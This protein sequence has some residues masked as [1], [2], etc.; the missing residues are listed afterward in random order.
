MDDYFSGLGS[1]MADFQDS[2]E[3]LPVSTTE[4]RIRAVLGVRNGT[5]L[6]KVDAA[7]MLAYYRYLARHFT[8]PCDARY[9]SDADGAVSLVTVTGLIDPQT[10]PSDNLAGLCCTAYHRNKTEILPLVDLEVGHDSPN[11]QF[12]E[13]YWF[14]LWNWRESRSY[15]PSKPR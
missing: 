13:D 8:L 3:R 5:E 4:E 11:F 1:S 10:M 12:L 14:W 9:S 15:R 6:P 2:Y 7:T